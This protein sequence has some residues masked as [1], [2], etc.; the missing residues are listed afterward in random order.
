M[1]PPADMAS[2]AGRPVADHAFDPA[3]PVA[4]RVA[5]Y[6]VPTMPAGKA[7]VA[8][9]K[10]AAAKL[11]VKDCFAWVPAASVTVTAAVNEPGAGSVPEMVPPGEIVKPEARPVADHL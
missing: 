8:I 9:A 10:G 3:P 7:G 1:T 5:E 11:N 6:A 2:P 4:A